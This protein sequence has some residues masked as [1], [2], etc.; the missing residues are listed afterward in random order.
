MRKIGFVSGMLVG[1]A[2]VYLLDPDRGRRRRALLR[3][4]LAHGANE[5]EEVGGWLDTRSRHLRNRASG[6]LVEAGA[7]LNREQVDDRKVRGV[8]RVENRLDVHEHP[9]DVPELQG[10]R[11]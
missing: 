1:A 3:D 11:R 5:L 7:R 10:I 2:V 6:A 4:R 9:G 8:D